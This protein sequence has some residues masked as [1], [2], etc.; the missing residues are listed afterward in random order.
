MLGRDAS[1]VE[2]YVAGVCAAIHL[3]PPHF[4]PQNPETLNPKPIF[5]NSNNNNTRNPEENLVHLRDLP[6]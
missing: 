4:A 5:F 2:M 6:V 1:D 3:N